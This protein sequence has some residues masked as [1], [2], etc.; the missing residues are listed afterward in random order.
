MTQD[1]ADPVQ[2]ALPLVP[3]RIRY[4]AVPRELCTAHDPR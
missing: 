1:V 3:T 4:R 2:R